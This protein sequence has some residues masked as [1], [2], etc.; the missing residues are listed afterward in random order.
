MPRFARLPIN[1]FPDVIRV[2]SFKWRFYNYKIITRKSIQK[3]HILFSNTYLQQSTLP[4]Y[5]AAICLVVLVQQMLDL[6]KALATARD[7]RSH[8]TLSRRI[9]ATYSQID[10]LVYDLYDLT[11]EEIKIVEQAS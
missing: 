5:F 4:K 2:F 8:E 3:L 11:E 1:G 6:H 7:P 10:R 9:A